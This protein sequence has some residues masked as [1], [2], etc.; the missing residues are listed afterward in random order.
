MRTLAKILL[1]GL[2]GCRID[3]YVAPPPVDGAGR[4]DGDAA[5]VEVDAGLD[6]PDGPRGLLALIGDRPEVT[7]SCGALDDRAELNDRFDPPMQQQVVRAG[8]EFDTTADD[9][10]DP[11]YGF[12]PAWTTSASGRF[13][14]R[15]RGRI[16]LPAGRH[17]V[18]VDIGATGND[19]IGGRNGCGQVWLGGGNTPTA[20][21]GYEAATAGPA[22]GCVEVATAGPVELDLVFWYFN[23]FEPARLRVRHCAGASCTPDQPLALETLSPP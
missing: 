6:A 4:V 19:I 18:S 20:E 10:R 13:S 11:S 2:T 9:Y 7:G 14:V 8:W 16:Q 12:D 15:F 23:I 21:T 1:V 5:S 3:A 22:T 17:C